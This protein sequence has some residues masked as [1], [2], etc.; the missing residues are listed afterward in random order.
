VTLED[1]RLVKAT[2]ED[3]PVVFGSG[4]SE[5][6]N[7]LS[8]IIMRAVLLALLVYAFAA[9]GGATPVTEDTSAKPDTPAAG[10][11]AAATAAS[12]A[13]AARR[14][15]AAPSAASPT[16]RPLETPLPDGVL[17]DFEYSRLIDM[18][19]RTSV[20]TR[21][22][23]LQ[24]RGLSPPDAFR[25]LERAFVEK[26]YRSTGASELEGG[27]LTGGFSKGGEGGGM[28]VVVA[29]GGTY[30]HVVTNHYD[31]KGRKSGFTG[32]LNITI[33]TP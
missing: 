25:S 19:T 18:T 1:T 27:N 31:E 2:R 32:G 7:A 26:G 17:P 14:S 33:H 9:C 15:D 11:D 28:T 20:T 29:S 3:R 30:V 8:S 12:F 5:A 21:Q 13:A 6:R 10:R 4:R 22:V 24:V 23:G 16:L